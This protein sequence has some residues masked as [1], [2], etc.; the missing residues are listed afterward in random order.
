MTSYCRGCWY[1]LDGTSSSCCPECG[2]PFDLSNGRTYRTKPRSQWW[3][4]AIFCPI[5]SF[6]CLLLV[7]MTIAAIWAYHRCTVEELALA[8][9]DQGRLSYRLDS[10]C[11]TWMANWA[12]TRGIP[13]PATVVHVYFE[14]N[15]AAD[16]DLAYVKEFSNLESLYLDGVKITDMGITQL[17]QLRHLKVLWLSGTRVTDG[18]IARLKRHVPGLTVYGP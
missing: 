2:R 12:N 15:F 17:E 8:Q 3:F 10:R 9:L 14:T 4:D 16:R 18:G 13:L 6:L 5:A 7:V 11:P 1:R